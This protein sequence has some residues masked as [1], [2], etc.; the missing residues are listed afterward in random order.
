MLILDTNAWYAYLM[1]FLV[2]R[3]GGEAIWVHRRNRDAVVA[4]VEGAIESGKLRIPYTVADE[5]LRG[6]EKAFRSAA[7]SAGGESDL[8]DG[9]IESARAR[10][11][12]LYATYGIPDDGVFLPEIGNMYTGALR[13]PRMGGAVSLWRSVKERH[14]RGGAF[15]ALET[16]LADFLILSTAA[17]QVARGNAVRL[18]TFDH[19]L[20]AFADA[21]RERFGVVVVDGG[22]LR[23]R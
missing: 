11:E 3:D 13:D 15:P 4:E 17:G 1:Y 20:V 7:R 22:S 6:M 21:I 23:S 19:D 16:H 2:Y 8:D 14:G 18:L 10:F 5:T 12:R 9:I